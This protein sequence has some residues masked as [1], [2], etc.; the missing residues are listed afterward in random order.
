[1]CWDSSLGI[2]GPDCLIL[3]VQTFSSSMLKIL[4]PSNHYFEIA[5]HM[6]ALFEY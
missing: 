3:N 1:M 6:C 4:L 2:G 5:F